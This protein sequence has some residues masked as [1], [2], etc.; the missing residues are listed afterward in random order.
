MYKKQW[1]GNKITVPQNSDFIND[2]ALSPTLNKK[3][4][5]Q[6]SDS[7]INVPYYPSGI[8]D[9]IKKVLRGY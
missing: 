9:Y 2:D 6:S 7:F 4:S 8:Y 1:G 5:L 3:G